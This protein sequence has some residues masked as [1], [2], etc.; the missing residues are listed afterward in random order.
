MNTPTALLTDLLYGFL[1]DLAPRFPPVYNML[2]G[3]RVAIYTASWIANQGAIRFTLLPDPFNRLNS[4]NYLAC[5][6]H[7]KRGD[8]ARR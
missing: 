6:A 1:E 7:H 4:F 2:L 3:R 8:A 5:Q